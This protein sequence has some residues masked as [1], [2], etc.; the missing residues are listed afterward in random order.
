MELWKQAGASCFNYASYFI[1]SVSTMPLIIFR[2]FFFGVH[3]EI[4]FLTHDLYI[5]ALENQCINNQDF[6]YMSD[7]CDKYNNKVY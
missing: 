2:E 6:N 7:K 1:F 5:W 3:G 4:F